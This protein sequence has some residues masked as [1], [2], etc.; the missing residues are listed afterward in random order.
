MDWRTEKKFSW[1]LDEK[2]DKKNQFSCLVFTCIFLQVK[3]SVSKKY[4]FNRLKLYCQ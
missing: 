2:N 4:T 3:H 1:C